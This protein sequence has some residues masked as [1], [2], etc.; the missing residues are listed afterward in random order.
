MMINQL[1]RFIHRK[2]DN[3][4]ITFLYLERQNKNN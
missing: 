2:L 3:H 4:L 1:Y